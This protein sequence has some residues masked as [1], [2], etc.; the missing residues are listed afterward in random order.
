MGLICVL[1]SVVEIQALRLGYDGV[2]LN[3]Y[4]AIIAFCA[5][6][7]FERKKGKQG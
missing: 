4:F 3:T 6:S 1:A 7:I 2:L 5:G